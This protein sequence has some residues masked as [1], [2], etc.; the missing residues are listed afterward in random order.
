MHCLC[1]VCVCAGCVHD[2]VCAMQLTRKEIC[3]Y[4]WL[5]QVGRVEEAP[6]INYMQSVT[7]DPLQQMQAL[8]QPQMAQ[9]QMAHSQEQD[10]GSE[11]GPQEEAGGYRLVFNTSPGW[12]CGTNS[13][14]RRRRLHCWHS[15][16]HT[17]LAQYKQHTFGI[18]YG[19][20]IFGFQICVMMLARVS[21]AGRNDLCTWCSTSLSP[22]C[23]LISMF[24]CVI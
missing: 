12:F 8:Q 4:R 2:I 13:Q 10:V 6:I 17:S 1:R 11:G 15:T 14:V 22:P 18:A 20:A 7:V 21:M 16:I 19:A 23:A 5:R 3:V 24:A 9:L